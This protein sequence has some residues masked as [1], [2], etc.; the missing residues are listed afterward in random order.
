MEPKISLVVIVAS[1][2]IIS[3]VA[4]TYYLQQKLIKERNRYKNEIDSY[5]QEVGRQLAEIKEIHKQE[6]KSIESLY[7]P[8]TPAEKKSENQKEVNLQL[9]EA[10]LKADE[11]TNAA[12][13]TADS[14]ISEAQEEAKRMLKREEKELNKSVVKI[15]IQVVKR[16]LGKSLSYEDH[17]ELILKSLDEIT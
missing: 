3:L 13:D 17:K 14:I 12:E 4:M 5:Q 8:K 7:K 10:K 9:K 2:L 16:V 6:L 1:L 15:V 11:I